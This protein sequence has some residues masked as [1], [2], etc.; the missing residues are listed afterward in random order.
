MDLLCAPL[1]L[2]FGMMQG[3]D[4][5]IETES[6]WNT[7]T[8]DAEVIRDSE[9]IQVYSQAVCLQFHLYLFAELEPLSNFFKTIVHILVNS[10]CS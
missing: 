1:N 5:P 3:H 6:T 7:F 9:Y 2:F 4:Q 8:L 10:P